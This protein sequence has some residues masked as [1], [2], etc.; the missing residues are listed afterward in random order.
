[1]VLLLVLIFCAV[2][3]EQIAPFDPILQLNGV[4]RRYTACIHLLGCP[5]DKPQHLMGIDGNSRDL[6]S[7]IIFG[8]RLS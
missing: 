2:F 6:F 7:R 1:M 5:A 4:K 8:A 3:A